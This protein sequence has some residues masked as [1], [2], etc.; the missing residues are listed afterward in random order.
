MLDGFEL[1][2]GAWERA[3]LPS[4]LDRYEPSM[5]DMLCLAGEVGW[6][7]PLAI[8]IGGSLPAGA[9]AGDTDRAV[10]ARARGRVAGAAAPGEERRC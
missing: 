9:R 6:A 3:V 7:T 8:A 1:A 5:L 4:R 2:A 10:P